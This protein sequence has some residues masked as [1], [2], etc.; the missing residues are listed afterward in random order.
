MNSNVIWVEF[1]NMLPIIL[2]G[3]VLPIIF[4]WMETRRKMNETNARTQ[5]VTAALE[6]NPDMDVEEL[7]KKISPKKKLLKEKLLTK[8]LWGFIT[9]LLGIG[10]IVLGI[11][12]KSS[13]LGID[14]DV[15]TALCF[16]LILLAIGAA[17]IINYGVGRK[18]LAKEIE[19]E[20]SKTT[21]QV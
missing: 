13:G 18:M 6:K 9:S 11:Y 16:G 10:L 15:Q 7:L 14:V 20:E 12:M 2:C 17:F 3:C 8:L 21:T 1:I 19:A 5:I 4:I